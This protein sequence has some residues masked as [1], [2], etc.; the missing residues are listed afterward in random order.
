[1]HLLAGATDRARELVAAVTRW[2]VE[3]AAVAPDDLG[4]R[5]SSSTSGTSRSSALDEDRAGGVQPRSGCV[6]ADASRNTATA[7]AGSG[8]VI[9]TMRWLR[10]VSCTVGPLLT[11]QLVRFG[12]QHNPY[13]T[14][15][16][17]RSITSACSISSRR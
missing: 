1:M 2:L 5:A 9:V 16:D 11:V 6:P 17:D 15:H 3:A 10:S 4:A 12:V 7:A 13:E 14:R 8:T